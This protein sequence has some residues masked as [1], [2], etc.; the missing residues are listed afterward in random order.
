MNTKGQAQV[1]TEAESGAMRLQDKGHQGL[2]PPPGAGG[3]GKEP[4][5]ELLDGV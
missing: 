1:R 2:L 4:P 3:G 5:L